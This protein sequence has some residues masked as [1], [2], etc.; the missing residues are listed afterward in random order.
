MVHQYG[1]AN[2][3]TI[4]KRDFLEIELMNEKLIGIDSIK[5]LKKINKKQHPR[6]GWAK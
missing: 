3:N 6:R 4:L 5:E 2:A 1:N